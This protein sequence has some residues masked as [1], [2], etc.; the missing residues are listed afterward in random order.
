VVEANGSS[1]NAKL[2]AWGQNANYLQKGVISCNETWTN[3]RPYVLLD[4]VVV[5]SSCVLN[6]QPGVRVFSDFNAGLFILGSV[7]AEGSL[8]NRIEFRNSRL[9][10]DFATAPGQWKG[11]FVLEGSN[12]NIFRNVDIRNAD[13]GLRIGAPDDDSEFD[14]VVDGVIIENMFLSG[15]LSFTSDVSVRNSLIAN[16]GEFV[17]AGLAGGNYELN[18]VTLANFPVN[19]I[20]EN[21]SFVV[22]N[23][24]E[25]GGE[26]FS[27]DL[28]LSL[29][30]SIVWGSLEDEVL[31]S[32]SGDSDSEL[33]FDH[34]LFRTTDPNLDINSN[35]LNQDP[36][37]I[38]PQQF[39]FH[40]DSLSA[41]IDNG[42]ITGIVNDLD[43]NPRDDRP[44]M[45]CYERVSN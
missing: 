9:D 16:C 14:V 28:I 17:F 10:G 31:L 40:L 11:I 33:I 32:V 19:F 12:D 4:T 18:H 24:V 23:S 37:F 29:T 45:G 7:R 15:I 34:S 2:V 39:D 21:P 27:D 38:D 44:D 36:E 42:K 1:G 22:S 13:Y 8:D 30:N 3:E 43:G 5:D 25:I 20:R 35:I 26:I 41:A 6:I